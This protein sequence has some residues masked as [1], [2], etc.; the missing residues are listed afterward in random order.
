MGLVNL[1]SK[2]KLKVF[3]HMEKRY[4]T[5]PISILNNTTLELKDYNLPKMNLE[6]Y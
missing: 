6:T 5:I 4:I 2:I 3:N 1:N